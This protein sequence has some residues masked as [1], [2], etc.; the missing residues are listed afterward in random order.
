MDGES[1]HQGPG[2]IFGE[3]CSG[4]GACLRV[5]ADGSHSCEINPSLFPTEEVC[6]GDLSHGIWCQGHSCEAPAPPAP[7]SAPTSAPTTAPVGAPTMAPSA[8]P[9]AD[10]PTPAAVVGN[11]PIFKANGNV[12]KFHIKPGVRTPLLS[13]TAH[14]GWRDTEDFIKYELLGVTFKPRTLKVKEDSAGHMSILDDAQWFSQLTLLANAKVVLNVTR[15]IGG[16]GG[17][18]IQVDGK[19]KLYDAD[20]WINKFIGHPAPNQE[21][22]VT[23]GRLKKHVGNKFAQALVVDA[24]ELRFSIE[25]MPA[26]KFEN[27]E[28]QVAFGHLNLKFESDALPVSARG[29]LAQLAGTRALT[30]HNKN[31]FDLVVRKLQDRT[32]AAAEQPAGDEQVSHLDEAGQPAQPTAGNGQVSHIDDRA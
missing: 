16:F 8:A 18:G 3:Y 10:V 31:K 24:P 6:R 29:L 5:E 17:M 28:E 4:T 19:H 15:G 30:K 1:V 26:L 20:K 9:A 11:D 14:Q 25:T 32:D 13:W 27:E 21:M 22:L 2:S 12:Y 23:L 7:T